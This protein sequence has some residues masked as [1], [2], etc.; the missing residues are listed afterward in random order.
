LVLARGNFPG[1]V[2]S[3]G[4][5]LEIVRDLLYTSILVAM[6]ALAA[7][8]IIGLLV[9]IF[10]AVTSIQDQTLSYVPK[11]VLVAFIIIFTLAFSLD[12]AIAF[13]QRMLVHAAGAG[14]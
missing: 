8:L 6:P 12:L 13:T 14:S 2:M 3:V 1:D 11:I 5:V 4:Q 10:Q 9:S 7:S